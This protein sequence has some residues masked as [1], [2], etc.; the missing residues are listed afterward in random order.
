MALSL[1]V[2]VGIILLVVAWLQPGGRAVNVIDPS[3]TYQAARDAAHFPVRTP[4]GLSAKW[5]ATSARTLQLGGGRL[6][7]QVGFVTPRDE[8]AQLAESDL[9]RQALLDRELS[10][11]VRPTGSITVDG[12][13]WERLPGGRPGDRAIVTTEGRVTFLVSGSASLEELSALAAALY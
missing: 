6:L 3:P 13:E 9:P 10:R 8:Y 4:H 5:R 1:A 12:R 2:I 11:G 7:L